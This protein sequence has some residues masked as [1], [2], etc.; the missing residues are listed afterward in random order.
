MW[1]KRLLM[2]PRCALAIVLVLIT[3]GIGFA[4]VC[5]EPC[6]GDTA[7]KSCP[8]FCSFCTMCAHAQQA[9]IDL[10]ARA[11]APVLMARS[12]FAAPAA[13]PLSH[14]AADVFHIPL[15]A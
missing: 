13:A 9:V 11:A 12:A 4:P 7:Q 1:Y 6:P 10:P 8:P 15:A 14:P 2:S 3:A 5:N